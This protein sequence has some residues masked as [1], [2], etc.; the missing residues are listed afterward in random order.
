MGVSVWA[1]CTLVVGSR[2]KQTA[3][4]VGTDSSVGTKMLDT[5]LNRLRSEF[6]RVRVEQQVVIVMFWIRRWGICYVSDRSSQCKAC[7]VCLFERE[8]Q[9]ENV[10]VTLKSHSWFSL[11]QGLD[12]YLDLNL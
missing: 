2:N 8:R 6:L 3:I 11:L 10:C 12:Q 7:D 1:C 9:L 5:S 4:L